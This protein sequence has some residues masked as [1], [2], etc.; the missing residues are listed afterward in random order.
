MS[1]NVHTLMW[2]SHSFTALLVM[3][4]LASCPE[5]RIN[6]WLLSCFRMTVDC[7]SEQDCPVIAHLQKKNTGVPAVHLLLIQQTLW[8]NVFMFFLSISVWVEFFLEVILLFSLTLSCLRLI[9]A[10]YTVLC[11]KVKCDEWIKALMLT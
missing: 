7:E 9:T 10:S 8:N 6:L 3:C 1:T 11:W 4:E 5:L 2:H